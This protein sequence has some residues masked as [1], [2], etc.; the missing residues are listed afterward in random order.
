[1]TIRLSTGLRNHILSGGSW[2]SAF[3]GGKLEIYTGAQPASA[4]T[5]PSGT[6]ILTYTASSGAHTEEVKPTGT[7][8]LA[9]VAGTVTNLKIDGEDLMNGTATF[10]DTLTNLAI[11][12]RDIINR[13]PRNLRFVASA[14]SATVTIT[15]RPGI[16]ANLNAIGVLVTTGAGGIT[17]TDTDVG[18]VV[19]GVTPLN[20]LQFESASAGSIVKL[21]SQTWS[22]VAASTNTAGWFR[23]KGPVNDADGT[24]SSEAVLRLDGSVTAA[25]GGG[26]LALASVSLIISTTYSIT[27]FTPTEPAA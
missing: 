19:A 7:A 27:T 21:A 24:D 26:D 13:N 15:G 2:R 8:V 5:A 14:S 20:G 10:V 9:G 16:G 17:S 1:M 25:G 3:N 11:A 22:G 18:N 4:D 12:V 6:K 23:L